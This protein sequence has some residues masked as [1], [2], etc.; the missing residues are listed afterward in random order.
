[1]PRKPKSSSP[2][3]LSRV[4]EQTQ[5]DVDAVLEYILSDVLF[6]YQRKWLLDEARFKIAVK[7][8][9]IGFSLMF[10]LEGLIDALSGQ[11]VFYISR[12]ERQSIEL[13]AKFYKW[14]DFFASFDIPVSFSQRNTVECIVNGVTVKSLTSNAVAGEGYTGNVY[15]DEFALHD[16]DVR[17]YRSLLPTIT[18]G[19][20]IRIISRPFGQNNLF[21]EIVTNTEKYPDYSRHRVNIHDAVS[22]GLP[23]DPEELRRNFDDEGWRENYL[24]EFIDESTSYFPYSLLRGA[25]GSEPDNWTGGINYVG[26][27]IGRRSDSTVIFVLSKLGDKLYKRN[28]VRLDR[29]DFATQEEEVDRIMS[30]YQID[31]GLIDEGGLGM[32]LAE[33]LC[34]KHPQLKTYDFHGDRKGKM[35]MTVKRKLEDK[36]LV[37]PDDHELLSEFHSVRKRVTSNNNIVFEATRNSG[38]H[39]DAFT[40]CGLAVMASE[41]L[42]EPSI[43][44][45]GEEDTW[46]Q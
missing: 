34:E 12:T 4:D 28:V 26:I 43:V 38:G 17:I 36:V 46:E 32:H 42:V 14:A 30:E 45:L 9:Q 23:I 16:N 39:V 20:K 1:M 31:S 11:P 22:D 37:L 35:M 5:K 40:A 6:D 18:W 7:A 41:D 27:D 21:H 33:R 29:V 19:Y 15:L 13:L 3:R 25:I 2:S 10:G 44:I 24:C 8:R